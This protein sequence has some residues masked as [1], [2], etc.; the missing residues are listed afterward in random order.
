MFAQKGSRELKNLNLI[1]T[2]S[3]IGFCPNQIVPERIYN[4][5]YGNGVP[6]MFTSGASSGFQPNQ[7]KKYKILTDH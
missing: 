2:K 3:Q 1:Q 6:A 5:H 7:G 4:P